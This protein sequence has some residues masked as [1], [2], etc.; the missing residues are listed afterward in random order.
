M[1]RYQT[2]METIRGSRPPMPEAEA[3]TRRIMDAVRNEGRHMEKRRPE[4]AFRLTTVLVGA[5]AIILA[6]MILRPA[7]LPSANIPATELSSLPALQREDSDLMERYRKQQAQAL[8]YARAKTCATKT[9]C[10]EKH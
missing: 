4:P 10:H 2:F 8:R 7:V 6:L 5:A 1:D 3:N 9:Y